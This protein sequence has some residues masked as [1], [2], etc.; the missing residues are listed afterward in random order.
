MMAPWDI[1]ILLDGGWPISSG[2]VPHTGFHNPIGD[3]PYWLTALGMRIGPPSLA[4][5]VHGNVLFLLVAGSG[6]CL[7]LFRRHLVHGP[8]SP[9]GRAGARWRGFRHLPDHA[10]AQWR[11]LR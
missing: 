10:G 11:L 4:S 7:V 5:F 9:A 2:Q 1:F 3:L 6:I 8:A